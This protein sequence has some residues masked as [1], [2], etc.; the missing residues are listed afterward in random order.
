MIAEAHEY[1]IGQIQKMNL[2]MKKL[3]SYKV[4]KVKPGGY[5]YPN[6]AIKAT[7]PIEY[8]YADIKRQFENKSVSEVLTSAVTDYDKMKEVSESF[9]AKDP[10]KCLVQSA[11]W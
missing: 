11:T 2:T 3:D 7:E 5:A 9:K 8:G 6:H 1:A 10:S 4:G